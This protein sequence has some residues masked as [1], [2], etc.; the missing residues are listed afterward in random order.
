MKYLKKVFFSSLQDQLK[1]RVEAGAKMLQENYKYSTALTPMYAEA[2]KKK[3]I[4]ILN[5]IIF[6]VIAFLAVGIRHLFTQTI[7]TARQ[8][9][10]ITSLGIISSIGSSKGLTS[11]F[12]GAKIIH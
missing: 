11:L 6:I 1:A 7:F 5:A 10:G 4:I 2:P 8:L 9:N 3:E 12:R